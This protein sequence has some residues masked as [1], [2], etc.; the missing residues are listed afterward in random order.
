MN[1]TI[2]N[3]LLIGSILLFISVIAG[4]T[5]YKFGVPTLILFLAIGMLAGSE[6]I[7]GIYFD[8]PS[9]SRFIGVVALNFILFSGGLDTSWKTIRPV[10]WQGVTLSTLGVLI[11]CV[12]VGLFV[13]LVTDFSIYEGLLLGAIV[14]S[15]DAAAV[16]SILRSKNLGL[17][18]KLRPLLELESGSNDPMAYFL[19]VAFL[20]LVVHQDASFFSIIPLFFTQLI[21]G[22]VLG[23]A[24]GKLGYIVINKIALE[25]EGLYPVLV[26]ALMFFTFSFTDFIYGNGFLAVYIAAVY[27]GNHD[28]IHKKTILKAFDGFAW[29]MQ[30]VLFLTLGLLVYPSQVV[31]VVGIGL[32]ISGFLILVARPLSVFL[33]LA[34]FKMK[35]KCRWFVSWVGL[36]G[37]VPIVFA[38]YPLIANLEKSYMIFNIVFFIS[39]SSVILQGTSLPLAG[40]WLRVVLPEKAKPKTPLDILLNDDEKSEYMEL[41]IT[42]DSPAIGKKVFELHFPNTA[43]IALIRRNK[44]YLV[45]KG[46]TTLEAGDQLVILSEDKKGLHEASG[47]LTGKDEL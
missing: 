9:T 15:T 25:Y 6:G 46:D 26:I 1:L 24:F 33:C 8:D 44:K 32:L 37:A 4:K 38:T 5:S 19:T 22:G 16:F 17:K 23:F 18:D 43:I 40:K 21:I 29:L 27:L 35:N 14:S 45:P 41:E 36:K 34:F 30:I 28:L 13:Y 31:P 39:V 20:G 12:S 10:M 2:E 42:H 47:C 11:T 3:I 7:G